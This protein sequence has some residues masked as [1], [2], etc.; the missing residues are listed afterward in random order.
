[1]DK[2]ENKSPLWWQKLHSH[3]AK[4][5]DA[6]AEQALNVRPIFAIGILIYYCMPWAENETF[7]EVFFSTPSIIGL[8]YFIG[9]LSIITAI[10]LNPVP[11]PVRR[12]CAMFLDI[13]ALSIAML[14]ASDKSA[15]LFGIYLWVCIGYGFRYGIRYLVDATILSLIGFSIAVLTGDYWQDVEHQK[16]ALSYIVLLLLIPFYCGFLIRKMNNAIAD[17]NEAN[18]AKSRFLANMSHELRTPLNG[19][20]GTADLLHET[21]LRPQ[22]REFVS[23]MQNSAHTLLELIEDILDISKIEAG[24]VTTTK[25]SFDIY[26]L[27][28]SV[29]QLQ[30]PLADKKNLAIFY[31]IDAAIPF[32]LYADEQHLKQ[33]LL[34]LL[35]NAVKFTD[36]GHIKL[37]VTVTNNNPQKPMLH[38]EVQD[39]GIGIAPEEIN[40]IFDEFNQAET[41]HKISGTGLGTTIAKRLVTLMGGEIGVDSQLGQGSVFWFSLPTWSIS[42]TQI[43]LSLKVMLLVSDKTANKIQPFLAKHHIRHHFAHST[44]DALNELMMP[45]QAGNYNLMLVEASCIESNADFVDLIHSEEQLHTLPLV[46][47]DKSDSR[48]VQG[49]VSVLSTIEEQLFINV[50]HHAQDGIYSFTPDASLQELYQSKANPRSLNVLIAED[51]LVNQQVLQG[52]LSHIG[53]RTTL[54]NS[55]T[56][57]LKILR[58]QLD[59]LD[60]VIL[61]VNMPQMSGIEI[62]NHFSQHHKNGK[63]PPVLM[64]TADVTIETQQACL[65]AGAKAFL[66]KPINSRVLINEISALFPREDTQHEHNSS[67][68][69]PLTITHNDWLDSALLRDLCAVSSDN[70]F[71]TQLIDGFQKDASKHLTMIK[72]TINSD[73]AS[74][75]E[76]VHALK[77]SAQGI[78]AI[79]LAERCKQ[80]E[81]FNANQVGAAASQQTIDELEEAFIYS[82]QALEQFQQQKT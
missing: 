32:N 5:G 58:E 45:A 2:A 12:Y 50:L 46:L 34:N 82:F 81:Q 56:Q 26:E 36:N 37:I 44:A 43:S 24:K 22:Q 25:A 68:P 65:N 64:L 4:T 9:T 60:L 79:R 11:S 63:L 3:L 74:Y 52:I 20:I 21:D 7:Q 61:D 69:P 14:L 30:R 38:F 72:N 27:I 59:K 18:Q 67:E 40:S 51:N 77:G 8:L 76:S 29:V 31:H 6:E 80:A 39:T 17:A 53:H 13:G 16:F 55:G 33:V 35:S 66:T 10:Y 62:L 48:I 73:L 47:L 54:A 1:M 19:V 41:K 28:K 23:I 57:A 70:T 49:Y 42:D 75:R 15:A 71:L 78:G